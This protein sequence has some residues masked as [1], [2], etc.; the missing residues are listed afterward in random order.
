GAPAVPCAPCTLIVTAVGRSIVKLTTH[1]ARALGFSADQASV[2]SADRL[3]FA[4]DRGDLGHELWKSDET[5]TALV[6]GRVAGAD[7]AAQHLTAVGDTPYFSGFDPA[8]GQRVPWRS[9]GGSA[10][11]MV[12]GQALVFSAPQGLISAPSLLGFSARPARETTDSEV[13]RF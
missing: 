13:F 3:F 2:R 12:P 9:V 7:V 5:G 11:S 8:S 1:N 10:P 4:T 6:Q